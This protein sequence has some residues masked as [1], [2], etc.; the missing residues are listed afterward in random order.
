MLK[1]WR[2]I[3]VCSN[4]PHLT[5]SQTTS[6]YAPAHKTFHRA[7]EESSRRNGHVRRNF[8]SSPPLLPKR[9]IA[10]AGPDGFEGGSAPRGTDEFSLGIE[11]SSCGRVARINVPS[12]HARVL[13]LKPLAAAMNG[14][15]DFFPGAWG[16]QF[17]RGWSLRR[18]D[19]GHPIRGR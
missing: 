3:R 19:A 14:L 17:S 5:P 12:F 9:A 13:P 8:P 15:S 16:A 10:H 6:I 18:F 4:I 1:R 2:A 11:S 7:Q